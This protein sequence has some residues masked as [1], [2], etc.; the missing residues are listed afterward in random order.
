MNFIILASFLVIT[1]VA[2]IYIRK[3][4]NTDK[5]ALAR[6][7][8]KERRSNS[9]RKK[10]LE[11][12]AYLTIPSDILSMQPLNPAA[13]TISYIEELQSLSSE[14]IVNLTG[15]S[16]TDLKLTYGTA[17][18]TALSEY[19]FHYTHMVTVLQ[20]LAESLLAADDKALAVRVLEFAVS[21]GTDVSQTYYLLADLYRE[22]GSP[23]K[24][25]TLIQT[26]QG[27]HTLKKDSILR[28]LTEATDSCL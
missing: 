17:N 24:I 10:S 6:F 26:A 25:R 1:C 3:N 28:Y 19:D 12:L 2:N 13:Q 27:L 4:K 9:V 21:T 15:I 18:I 22:E 7:W 16:N 14:K 5:E 23:E 11:D 20:K 8:D